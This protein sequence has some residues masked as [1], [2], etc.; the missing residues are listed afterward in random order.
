VGFLLLPHN[1]LYYVI[2]TKLNESESMLKPVIHGI[3]PTPLIFTNIEREF[4]KEELEF[5]DE[6]S[7]TTFK[8]EGNVTSLDNYLMRHDPMT[9]IKQEITS[10]LQLYLDEVIKPKDDVKPYITQSWLNYTDENQYHHKHAHPNSFLSGVM[11]VNADP[12]KDKITFFND[13]MYKQIKLFPK[14]WNLYNAESWFFTV[15][16]GDIVIF[17]SSLIHMVEQ[18]A[19]NN[20]RTSLAFNSFLRGAIGDKQSLTELLN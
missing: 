20:I 13:S 8:N 7:K 2:I 15:K 18:K 10:A 9:T 14:E 12:E 4:T 17:P 19:G 1:E 11:Y 16:P 3:F 5:F 6:Q